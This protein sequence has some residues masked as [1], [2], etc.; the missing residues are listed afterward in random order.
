MTVTTRE[1]VQ[2]H[3]ELKELEA[4]AW[5][6]GWAFDTAADAAGLGSVFDLCGREPDDPLVVRLMAL[7]DAQER[8]SAA[9]QAFD[10]KSQE[11]VAA[12]RAAWQTKNAS[13]AR[14]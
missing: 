11:W 3:K 9:K 2:M 10:A 12:Q 13:L 5:S 1:M 8:F 4:K 6:A 7:W 14:V